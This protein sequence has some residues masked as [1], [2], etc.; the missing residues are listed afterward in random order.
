MKKFLALALSMVLLF[1]VTE[2][3]A[4]QTPTLMTLVAGDT[5]T[6]SS[7]VDSVT[8]VITVTSG[9]SALGIQVN[10]AKISGTVN[11][12]AYLMGSVDGTNYIVSDSSAAFANGDNVVQFT[13]S[14]TPFYKYKVEVRNSTGAATTQSGIVRVYYI[15]RRHN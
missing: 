7:S 4:A 12:K 6:T 1:A 15:A 2:K 13:K 9:Y 3:V 11:A 10:F 5:L 14:S 8:K